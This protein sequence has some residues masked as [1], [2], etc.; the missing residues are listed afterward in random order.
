M[1][2]GVL[3]NLYINHLQSTLFMS[4]LKGGPT[5]LLKHGSNV[6]CCIVM[7]KNI[8]SSLPLDCIDLFDVLLSVEVP[9]CT[10]G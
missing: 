9:Y 7:V 3:V 10:S 1:A 5:E 2:T 4:L 8:A 6:R